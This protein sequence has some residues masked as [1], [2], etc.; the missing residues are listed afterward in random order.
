MTKREQLDSLIN[1]GKG[2][3]TDLLTIDYPAPYRTN[4]LQVSER[5]L[6]EVAK[7]FERK[8]LGKR[9]NKRIVHFIAIAEWDKGSFH[10]HLLLKAGG[11]FQLA[12]IPDK[13]EFREI[14]FNI[15]CITG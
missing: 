5:L 6:W 13:I 8:L 3:Y 15:V 7:Y 14:F 12:F 10:W 9:W 2:Q 1:Q 4:D 11:Y